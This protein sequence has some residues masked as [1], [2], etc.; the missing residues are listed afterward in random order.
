[1]IRFS[2]ITPTSTP[3]EVEIVALRRAPRQATQYR[4]DHHA[5]ARDYAG[6]FRN[7][8]LWGK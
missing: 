2:S 5:E 1:M 8:W 6:S 7:R 3:F 4:G